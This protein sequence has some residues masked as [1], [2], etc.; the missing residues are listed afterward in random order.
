MPY[1]FLL[2][3]YSPLMKFNTKIDGYIHLFDIYSMSNF[4]INIYW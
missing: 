2:Y 3:F 1:M 4:S